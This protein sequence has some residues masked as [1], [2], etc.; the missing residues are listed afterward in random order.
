[1]GRDLEQPRNPD[2]LYCTRL[3][4]CARQTPSPA[5]L[6]R[7][8]EW[9][10]LLNTQCACIWLGDAVIPVCS[11]HVTLCSTLGPIK[12]RMYDSD[13][14][15]LYVD[16]TALILMEP[17]V[18]YISKKFRIRLKYYTE[19]WCEVIWYLG[20]RDSIVWFTVDLIQSHWSWTKRWPLTTMGFAL[21]PWLVMVFAYCTVTILAER[22]EPIPYPFTSV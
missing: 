18:L 9:L 4:F 10:S 1:M 16:I 12:K 21:A 2:K 8:V 19:D 14:Q 3:T 6:S 13:S 22:T 5:Y 20:L 17:F 15:W 11:F 7:V